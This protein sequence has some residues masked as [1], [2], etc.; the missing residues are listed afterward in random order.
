MNSESL[1]VLIVEDEEA[2][3]GRIAELIQPLLAAFPGSM[4]TIVRSKAEAWR[5]IDKIPAPHVVLLD[6]ALED[7]FIDD[8]IAS[9][10]AMEERSAVVIVTGSSR[11]RVMKTLKSK[12]AEIIEKTD[13][14]LSGEPSLLVGAIARAMSG[15]RKRRFERLDAL[16]AR[17][18]VVERDLTEKARAHGSI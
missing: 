17:A 8:T 15:W 1:R 7:S 12:T 4:V 2:V 9:V 6:L 13:F 16:I 10:E 5:T 18:K 3:S 11:E 14:I